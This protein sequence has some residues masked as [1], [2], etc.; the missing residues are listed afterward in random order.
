MTARRVPS[1]DSGE[2]RARRQLLGPGTQRRGRP[3]HRDDEAARVLAVDAL[4]GSGVLRRPG[5]RRAL[6]RVHHR[7]SGDTV[8][9]LQRA[10]YRRGVEH[11]GGIARGELARFDQ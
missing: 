2:R 1:L 3:G 4:Y 11:D 6:R 5:R 9:V 8:D 10:V 7:G